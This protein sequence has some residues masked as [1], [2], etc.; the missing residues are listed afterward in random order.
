MIR[1]EAVEKRIRE[2][3][4]VKD[5][6]L[7]Q[8]SILAEMSRRMARCLEEGGKALFFGNGG[9]AADAQHMACELA[10]RFYLERR[11]LPA[12]ALTVNTSSLTAIGN[13]YGFERVFSRQLEGIGAQGDV[14]V[15]LSTSGNS[16]N[17]LHAVDAARR[18]GIATFGWTGRGGGALR[19]RVDLCLSVDSDETPRIQE[20]HILAGHILCELV[21]RE[22]FR[23][24]A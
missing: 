18:M 10:G 6:L 22:I 7:A 13:D 3:I 4:R 2:A 19:D 12:L 1:P 17:V 15:A 14:A 20:A 9:S 16:P 5:A 8:S 23:K 24:N 11:S 21:E